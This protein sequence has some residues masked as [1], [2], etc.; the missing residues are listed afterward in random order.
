[1]THR[2]KVASVG[3]HEVGTVLTNSLVVVLRVKQLDTHTHKWTEAADLQSHY[4]MIT[5]V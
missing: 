4:T 1:M 2:F 3:S 5:E